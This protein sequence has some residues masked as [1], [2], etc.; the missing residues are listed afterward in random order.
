MTL[1]RVSFWKTVIYKLKDTCVKMG[2]FFC[3]EDEKGGQGTVSFG[4]TDTESFSVF[5]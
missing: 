4:S 3:Y 1:Y 5:L 2:I